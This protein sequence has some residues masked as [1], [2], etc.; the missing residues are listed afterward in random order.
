MGAEPIPDKEQVQVEEQASTTS[1][2][3][4]KGAVT[5]YLKSVNGEEDINDD[6]YTTVLEKTVAEHVI[7]RMKAYDQANTNLKAMIHGDP[8]LGRILADMAKGARFEEVLPRYYDANDFLMQPGDPDYSKW[9]AANK[10]RMAS[11]QNSLDAETQLE[12]NRIKSEE[13]IRS[14]FEEKGLQDTERKEYGSFVA[15]LL[16]RAYA[17]EITTEFLNKMFYAWKYQDDV[18]EAEKVGELRGR[19]AKI[20][21][22]K[23]EEDLQKEGDGLPVIEGGVT[24]EKEAPIE[25][26]P[27][28]PLVQSLRERNKRTPVIPGNY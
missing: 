25:E 3:E 26:S 24:K 1:E 4:Y 7:P 23:M 11:Y 9:E 12:N 14:W 19:N 13:T 6:N 8:K 15:E 28:D 17:G 5:E 10:E 16:D 20:V 27:A 2:G 21:N 22:E 18:A